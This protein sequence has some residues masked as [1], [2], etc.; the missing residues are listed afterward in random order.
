LS[1]T[2]LEEMNPTLTD[3]DEVKV[4]SAG[5]PAF[6]Q[7][8]LATESAVNAFLVV[9]LYFL[10]SGAAASKVAISSPASGA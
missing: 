10:H 5:V 9:P 2:L 1:Q 8:P 7:R 4:N 3:A 6:D